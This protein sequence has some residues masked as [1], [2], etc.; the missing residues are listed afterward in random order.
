MPISVWF[1]PAYT[2]TSSTYSQ[3]VN[4]WHDGGTTRGVSL[5][6]HHNKLGWHISENSCYAPE[7]P[8]S[9]DWHFL[10]GVWNGSNMNLFLDNESIANISTSGIFQ[11]QSVDLG[12]GGDPN[13]LVP[14]FEGEI[15][16]ARIYNRALSESEIQQLYNKNGSD[17]PSGD[18]SE[19]STLV[20]NEYLG[21]CE[22][23]DESEFILGEE[24]FVSRIKIWYDTSIGGDT[25]RANIYGPD[26][27]SWSG[28]TIKER[29]QGTSG[30]RL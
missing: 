22:V 18:C 20:E 15:D 7:Q 11:N 12:I 23:D 13:P 8:I 21:A 28:S 30:V 14:F 1:K 2:T 29:C 3:F 27:Y 6:I 26:G 17:V 9:Q 5:E 25:L 16:D 19:E 10:I 24:S 4:K